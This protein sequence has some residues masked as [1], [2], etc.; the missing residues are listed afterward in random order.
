MKK[1]RLYLVKIKR[2]F[3]KCKWEIYYACQRVVLG[4]DE[5]DVFEFFPS[6]L[7]RNRKILE[8]FSK[9]CDSFP[10]PLTDSIEERNKYEEEW[11]NKIS[12][13]VMCFQEADEETS[14]ITDKN[15]LSKKEKFIYRKH[16][17]ETG[18]KLLIENFWDLW[19]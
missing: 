3:S 12:K 1:I 14:S 11:K 17:F 4:Y 18:M 13:M 8:E 9:N 10:C 2:W 15:E 7:S 16:Q 19:F 5:R 6:F